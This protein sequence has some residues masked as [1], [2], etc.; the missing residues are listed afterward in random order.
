RRPATGLLGGMWEFPCLEL[1][2]E[3]EV[4]GLLEKLARE[5]SAR[6]EFARV[7]SVRHVYSHFRLEAEV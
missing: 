2:E 5:Y 6:C 1:K 4:G 7:G 3:D